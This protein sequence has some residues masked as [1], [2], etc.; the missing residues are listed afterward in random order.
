MLYTA[1]S[2]R[3]VRVWDMKQGRPLH[4][5]KDHVHWVTTL[6]LNTDFVLH[7]GLHNHTASD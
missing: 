4:T 1:S 5:L 7:M 3:M 2:D 6:A